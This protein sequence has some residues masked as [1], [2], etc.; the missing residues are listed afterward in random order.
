MLILYR[1]YRNRIETKDQPSNPS[2]N[3]ASPLSKQSSDSSRSGNSSAPRQRWS[4]P[5]TGEEIVVAPVGVISLSPQSIKSSASTEVTASDDGDLKVL[6]RMRSRNL[7]RVNARQQAKDILR[8]LRDQKQSE[9]KQS[10]EKRHSP[11]SGKDRRYPGSYC[12]AMD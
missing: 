7:E 1:F 11:M 10:N 4:R 2:S 3:I 12:T 6:K 5:G 9:S 8:K